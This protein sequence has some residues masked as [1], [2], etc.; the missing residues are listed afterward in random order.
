MPNGRVTEALKAHFDI[1]DAGGGTIDISAYR[2]TSESP[3][4]QSYY[5][6]IAP[7]QCTSCALCHLNIYLIGLNRSFP[8]INLCY[9]SSK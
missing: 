2:R 6:E 4:S 9:S 1:V 7:P 8:W 3:H 5:E